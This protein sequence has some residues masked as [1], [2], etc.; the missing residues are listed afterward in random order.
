MACTV[1][2]TAISRPRKARYHCKAPDGLRSTCTMIVLFTDFGL[3]GPYVGQMRAVLHQMAPGISVIDLFADAPVGNC[4]ASA[5]LLAAYA[6]WFP[7]GTC[8]AG[9]QGSRQALREQISGALNRYC[10][11]GIECPTAARAA[12][13]GTALNDSP[14]HDCHVGTRRVGRHDGGYGRLWCWLRKNEVHRSRRLHARQQRLDQLV[15]LLSRRA[16]T[17]A[18]SDDMNRASIGATSFAGSIFCP[19]WRARTSA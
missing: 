14:A 12:A 4:R 10:F 6:A 15:S 3:H 16:R 2:R 1:W 13:I 8:R 5:Y 9:P 18:R 7:A 17:K 19:F 11:S